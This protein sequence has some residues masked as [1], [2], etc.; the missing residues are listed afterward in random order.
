MILDTDD[1]LFFEVDSKR[2]WRLKTAEGEKGHLGYADLRS[3][4][5]E[6]K[7]TDETLLGKGND[8]KFRPL[9]EYFEFSRS[10]IEKVVDGEVKYFLSRSTPRVPFYEPATVKVGGETFSGQC[11]TIATKGA[12]IQLTFE[13]HGKIWEGQRVLLRLS[14]ETLGNEV[15]AE[16]IVRNLEEKSVQGI[17]VEFTGINSRDRGLI[18]EFIKNC[19]KKAA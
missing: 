15:I 3:L 9:G 4:L 7:I 6:G 8:G 2:I 19:A 1:G 17:G 16:A 12:F 18:G 13:V 11:L 5:A 14:S 10:P